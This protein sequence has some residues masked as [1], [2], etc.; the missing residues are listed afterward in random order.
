MKLNA[1]RTGPM[2]IR[3]ISVLLI[4]AALIGAT[5]MVAAPQQ[6]HASTLIN[7]RR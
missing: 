3:F 7:A 1:F 2:V 4:G 6:S 5:L